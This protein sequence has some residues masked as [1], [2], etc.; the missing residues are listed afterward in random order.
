MTQGVCGI[1]K[2]THNTLKDPDE[3]QKTDV[4]RREN[5]VKLCKLVSCKTM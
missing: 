5:V 2:Y 4:G 1:G 3:N